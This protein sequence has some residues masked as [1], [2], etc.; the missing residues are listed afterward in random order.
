ME[1]IV[2][3]NITAYT[4]PQLQHG[5][6]II[7]PYM[8]FIKYN[9]DIYSI[10]RFNDSGGR[11]TLVSELRAMHQHYRIVKFEFKQKGPSDD[12]Y[13]CWKVESQG[14]ILCIHETWLIS[15]RKQMER[16][17]VVAQKLVRKWFLRRALWSG[18]WFNKIKKLR[19]FR[20]RVIFIPDDIV[21]T[22]FEHYF[23]LESIKRT[24]DVPVDR[25]QF[26]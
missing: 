17:V 8:G 26:E 2:K 13:L 20:K 7:L 9:N 1:R 24:G 23:A 21:W 12:D 6:A 25:V 10:M 18:T 3:R 22:L 15:C 16:R 14:R 19:L 11:N 4:S 5:E